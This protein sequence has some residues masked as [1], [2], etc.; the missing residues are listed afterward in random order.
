VKVRANGTF[1]LFGLIYDVIMQDDPLTRKLI[2]A[3]VLEP[4][5]VFDQRENRLTPQ[6]GEYSDCWLFAQ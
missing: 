6:W 5:L 3:D 2:L 1:N 4:E